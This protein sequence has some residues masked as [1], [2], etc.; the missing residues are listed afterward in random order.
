MIIKWFKYLGYTILGFVLMYGPVVL[1]VKLGN[2]CWMGLWFIFIPTLL[3][4]AD[5][6]K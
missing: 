5:R 3:V 1:S 2:M 6:K 4:I